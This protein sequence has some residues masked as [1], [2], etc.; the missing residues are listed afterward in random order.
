MQYVKQT[1]ILRTYK[2]SNA[3]LQSYNKYLFN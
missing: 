2:V 1:G 3:D